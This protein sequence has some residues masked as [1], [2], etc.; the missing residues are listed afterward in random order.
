MLK[1]AVIVPVVNTAVNEGRISCHVRYEKRVRTL[2]PLLLSVLLR[3]LQKAINQ[4]ENK[5][6]REEWKKQFATL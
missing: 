5:E 1:A 4:G 6:D 3:D 2:L